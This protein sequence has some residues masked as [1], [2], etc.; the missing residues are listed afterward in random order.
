MPATTDKGEG[1]K[2]KGTLIEQA[3]RTAERCGKSER[4]LVSFEC[5]F[6]LAR[7]RYHPPTV[8]LVRNLVLVKPAV[9]R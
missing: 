4:L 8:C 1:C 5:G 2:R 7:H 6:A 3:R 9:S